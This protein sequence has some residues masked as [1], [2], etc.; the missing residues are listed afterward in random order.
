MTF[1]FFFGDKKK[2]TRMW[3]LLSHAP[4]YSWISPWVLPT[5]TGARKLRTHTH[6][7]LYWFLRLPKIAITV[8]VRTRIW[9]MVKPQQSPTSCTTP[10]GGRERESFQTKKCVKI[11]KIISLFNLFLLLFMGFTALFGTIYRSH[12]YFN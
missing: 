5:R 12:C 6:P 10:A 2:G 11:M 3:Q 7:R 8:L 9:D 4:W 1:F